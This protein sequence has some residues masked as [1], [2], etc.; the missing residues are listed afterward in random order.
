MGV[1]LEFLK[2]QKT[3]ASSPTSYQKKKEKARKTNSSYC[4]DLKTKT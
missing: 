2:N 4:R 1:P 3:P